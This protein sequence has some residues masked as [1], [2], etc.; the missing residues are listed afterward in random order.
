MNDVGCVIEDNGVIGAPKS[1]GVGES[2]FLATADD[3]AYGLVI[4]DDSVV[5]RSVRLREK[6]F[7]DFLAVS[8][9][10]ALSVGKEE[11]GGV[12]G[13]IPSRAPVSVCTDTPL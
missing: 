8:P 2:V 6:F 7:V 1:V 13:L 4:R 12:N 3:N 11:S 10:L 9:E 5:L